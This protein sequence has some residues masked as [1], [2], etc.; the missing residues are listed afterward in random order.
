MHCFEVSASQVGREGRFV[1]LSLS[2]AG[3]MKRES[4]NPPFL[5]RPSPLWLF[6]EGDKSS[7]VD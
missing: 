4:R 5:E 7:A 1:D 2:G 6:N 3:S